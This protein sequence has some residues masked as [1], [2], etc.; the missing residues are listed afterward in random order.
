MI[1]R[2]KGREGGEEGGK[3]KGEEEKNTVRLRG[4]IL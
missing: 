3:E 2:R 1:Q 4:R